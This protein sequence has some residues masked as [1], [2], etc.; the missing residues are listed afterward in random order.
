MPLRDT[1]PVRGM[2]IA[3]PGPASPTTKKRQPRGEGCSSGFW[4]DKS[5]PRKRRGSLRPGHQAPAWRADKP[6]ERITAPGES[7]RSTR[8]VLQGDSGAGA[9]SLASLR[10]RWL[11]RVARWGKPPDGAA[12][13]NPPARENRRPAG[14]GHNPFHRHSRVGSGAKRLRCGLWWTRAHVRAPGRGDGCFRSNG[15]PRREPGDREPV[16]FPRMTVGCHSSHA[17][18]PGP[19]RRNPEQNAAVSR[20]AMVITTAV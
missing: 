2:L 12:A 15:I 9:L 14:A 3:Y 7:R 16:T 18:F 1:R 10:I 17:P 13:G 19:I 8:A 20:G 4:G 6:P 5:S 11:S